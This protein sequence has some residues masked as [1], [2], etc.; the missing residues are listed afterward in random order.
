MR[1]RFA[2]SPTGNLHI[3]SLRTAL[4]NWL[5]AQRYGGTY[6]VRIEDTDKDRSTPEFEA[7]IMAGMDWI[8]LSYDEGPDAAGACELY[9]QSERSYHA[10]IQQLLDTGH[11][12]RCFCTEAE[13]AVEKV[14]ADT[15]KQPYRYS[16]KCRR[17][18]EAEIQDRL[19]ANPP[20][21][22]R[23]AV[24]ESGEVTFLDAVRGSITFDLALL[25]DF[26]LA[27][28]DG[29]PSYHVAVVADDIAMGITHVLRGEDHISNTP[30]HILLFQAL[31]PAGQ[32]LPTF[33]H[34]PIILGADRSKL[35]KRH[36]ATAITDYQA[37]GFL[38]A[39]MINYL[40]LLGWSAPD[41]KEVQPVGAIIQQFSLDRINKAGAIFDTQKLTWMNKQYIKQLSLSDFQSAVHPFIE[42]TLMASIAKQVP[43]ERIDLVF[44]SVRD[45]LERLDQINAVLAVYA[46]TDT[47]RQELLREIAWTDDQKAIVAAVHTA[48]LPLSTF[49]DKATL[50]STLMGV[51][52]TLNMPTGLVFKT[53]RLV[54][55]GEASGPDLTTL[56]SVYP[57]AILQDRCR[58]IIHSF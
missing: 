10:V 15:A 32:E 48:W 33:G 30:K 6:I 26:I 46:R 36:G 45:S 35:S 8:G 19:K 38:P 49:S 52:K 12:Y 31:L 1:V 28:S 39:A 29:M 16:R 23:F 17:L 22:I 21:T 43:D 44:E 47:Q 2:P 40:A 9:R 3:G 13:L 34:F 27:K 37:Q 18:S 53:V 42:P 54:V 4:F 41:G 24:P 7:N 11:A 51:V 57:M 5:F 58:V 55:S 25:S 56:L 50:K 20:Y 14:A